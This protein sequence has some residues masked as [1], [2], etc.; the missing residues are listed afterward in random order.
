MNRIIP[1]QRLTYMMA[2]LLSSNPGNVESSL[3]IFAFA[4][5]WLKIFQNATDVA[6]ADNRDM[7]L[8]VRIRGRNAHFR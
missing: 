2:P 7:R 4:V 5:C 6:L 3:K 8:G 1:F